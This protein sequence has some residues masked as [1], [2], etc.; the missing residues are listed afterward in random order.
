MSEWLTAFLIAFGAFL[1]L[2]AAVGVLRMPDV[3]TR[4]QAAAK[5]STLGVGCLVL[6][7]AI[8]FEGLGITTQALLIMGFLL[9]T[10][11][12]AAHM[13]GRAAYSAEV[14]AWERSVVDEL[15]EGQSQLKVTR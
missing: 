1:S 10:T 6:A 4:L 14:P 5:A 9:L 15:Q 2:L 7:A 11:P 13:M 12:V 8:F 3:Y